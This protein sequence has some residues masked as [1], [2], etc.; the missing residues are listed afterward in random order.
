MHA[1]PNSLNLITQQY[2]NEVEPYLKSAES[3]LSS[4]S[5]STNLM[6]SEPVQVERMVRELFTVALRNLERSL[7]PCAAIPRNELAEQIE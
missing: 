4:I 7:S 6:T 3:L 2:F 1:I 5:F